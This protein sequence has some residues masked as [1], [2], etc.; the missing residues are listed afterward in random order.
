MADI[1]SINGVGGAG[2]IAL[3]RAPRAEA[4]AALLTPGADR[5]EFSDVAQRLSELELA[6]QPPIRA[7]KVADIREAISNGTYETDDKI[8]YVVGRLMSVLKP[9]DR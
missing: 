5:A 4:S 2:G 3:T 9:A 1:T 7:Q 6:G 8:E